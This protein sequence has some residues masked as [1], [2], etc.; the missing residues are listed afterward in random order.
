MLSRFVLFVLAATA[1]L[2]AVAAQPE[3][4]IDVGVAVPYGQLGTNRDVGLTGSLSA[5]FGT[6][7]RGVGLRTEVAAQWFFGP[8]TPTSSGAARFGNYN[9]YSARLA[10]VYTLTD[11]PTTGY[12]LVGLGAYAYSEDGSRNEGITGGGHLGIGLR[13]S[14]DDV[15]IVVEVQ[16]VYIAS[17]LVDLDNFVQG[18]VGIRF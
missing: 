1:P 7:D 9:S 6:G 11:R 8:D 18:T 15:T 16:N 10:V 4:G 12:A 17:S 13:S 5:G 3:L 2:A 14:L